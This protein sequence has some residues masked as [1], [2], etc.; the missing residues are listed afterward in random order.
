MLRVNH[1]FVGSVEFNGALFFAQKQH[2]SSRHACSGLF[3]GG[4]A[5]GVDAWQSVHQPTKA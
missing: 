1:R 5:G 3:V 4:S 2:K